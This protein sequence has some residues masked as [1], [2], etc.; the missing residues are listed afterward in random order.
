ML[1][2]LKNQI[3]KMR[4][5]RI[6]ALNGRNAASQVKLSSSPLAPSLPLIVAMVILTVLFAAAERYCFR[7]LSNQFNAGDL[8]FE[9]YPFVAVPLVMSMIK[10]SAKSISMGFIVLSLLWIAS[11]FGTKLSVLEV[12]LPSTVVL[13]STLISAIH[14]CRIRRTS[15]LFHILLNLAVV[16]VILAMVFFIALRFARGADY[17]SFKA[18]FAQFFF[19]F[20]VLNIEGI[21]ALFI[22][23]PII[24]LFVQDRSDFTLMVYANVNNHI[25]QRLVREAPSTYHHSLMVAD[26]SQAAAEAIGA[27]GLLARVGGYY[28]DIGKLTNPAYFMEN[29]TSHGNP[30]DNLPPS[31]SRMIIASHVKEG[32]ILARTEK[33]PLCISKM[34]A[35]HHGTTFMQW[36]KLKAEEQSKML[37]RN[38]SATMEGFYRYPGPL[39]VTKEESILSLADSIEAASRSL[40]TVDRSSVLRLVDNIVLAKWK[41]GQLS[42]S[43]LTGADIEA[44]K[45]SFVSSLIHLSHGRKAYPPKAR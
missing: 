18:V 39:P 40:A 27:N 3:S 26:L 11:G 33:L 19:Y 9:L 45:A 16:H 30:H 13:T 6:E 20:I 4:I 29:Q 34:I 31:V 41:D 10:G 32:L 25:L 38:G 14:A 42:Q 17:L 15:H 1:L 35:S 36:F 37:G 23:R 12:A 7:I 43:M 22:L 21:V 8:S 2:T 28:H 5:K 44:V 24:E